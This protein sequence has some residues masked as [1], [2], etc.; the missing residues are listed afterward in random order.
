VAD[1]RLESDRDISLVGHLEEFSARV[2][3]VILVLVC[4]TV[5]LSQRVE[6]LLLQWLD[7][8]APCTSCMVVFEPGAWIGLRWTT[9]IVC[10]GI[11]TLPLVVHQAVAFA[12]PALLP[13][14]RRRLRIGLVG[15][16]TI[17]LTVGLLFGWIGAPWVYAKAMQ[18]VDETGLV[19]ALDAVNLV[20]LTLAMMWI[21][22]L[23]GAAAGASLGAGALGRLDRERV[24]TWRWRVSLPV[25]LLIVGSTW[26]TTND[27]RWP[28]AI[29]CALFLELPL[30]PW[31]RAA[32]RT[33]PTVLDQEGGRRRLLVV[34]CA[35]DGAFGAPTTA[36]EGVF[37]HHTVK[38]LCARLSERTGLLERVQNG[39]ATDVVIVGCN[40]S[41]LPKRFREAVASTGANL[42]GLDLRHVEH[43]RPS[44]QPHS[45][46]MQRDL[47][48][49]AMVDPWSA[50]AAR[51][52]TQRALERYDG[53]VVFGSL[54]ASMA[55]NKV[56][57]EHD[58]R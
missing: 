23:L 11:L 30:L 22:A 49:A 26:A 20:Q 43:R 56:W 58:P 17:G 40:G 38:G 7:V 54:P 32:P 52:R 45:M 24:V 14:E 47:A 41:P 16:A 31:R 51:E 29:G 15:T 18:T 6:S 46:T 5:A 28:L 48:L 35:C 8:L 1:L 57:L 53:E 21:L 50:E 33:F 10:A 13:G 55:T 42:R 25:V 19:L 39:A 2:S 27:L 36:P 3:L 34:D 4:I 12:S 9:A 44:I 37:G